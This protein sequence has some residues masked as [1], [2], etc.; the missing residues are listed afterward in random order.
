[1]F[2]N[3]VF[4]SPYLWIF[5]FLFWIFF[6]FLFYKTKNFW[7]KV[8][9][10]EDL[11]K[12]FWSNNYLFKINLSIIFFIILISSLIIANPNTENKNEEIKRNWIDI[13]FVFDLSYSMMAKDLTPNRLEI[14]K[15]V[16]LNFVEKVESDRLWFVIF[17]WKPFVWVP[18]TFDYNFLFNYIKNLDIQKINQDYSHLQWTAIWDWLLYGAN[19]FKNDDREKVIVLLTDWEA[20]R[21]IDPLIALKYI[22]DKN[23]KI[24][25]VWIWWDKDTY[26]E[27]TNVFWTQKTP[28]WW[29]NEDMLKKIASITWWEYYRANS[30]EVFKDIFGKLSL[31]QKKDIEYKNYVFY[32]QEYFYLLNILYYLIWVF[33]IINF[34]FFV[35]TRLW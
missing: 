19:L 14:A 28:I 10:F 4:L 13:V 15:E 21:W 1:M 3:I 7:I 30:N 22:R 35:K 20:N 9:F 6:L 27:V 24:Y 17:S 26:V 8:S 18:L 23:I 16:L 29:V 25:T 5:S 31:I 32:K 33:L 12:V 2:E 34:Y 11:Q